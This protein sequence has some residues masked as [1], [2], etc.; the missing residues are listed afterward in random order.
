MTRVTQHYNLGA[1][2][3]GVDFVDVTVDG[4]VPVYIDPT[5]LRHQSGDWAERCVE[6]LQSFFAVLLAAIASDDRPALA[7]LIYPLSEPNETHLG[8]SEGSS[9][10]RSLGSAARAELLI[11]SLRESKAVQSGF[12]SDLEDSALMI[13][14]IDKDIISDIT[15]CVIRRQLIAYTQQQCDFLGI[16]ME[17]QDSGPAWDSTLKQWV[18][19]QVLLPRAGGDKLMLVPKAI[20]RAK[21]T[22]DKGHYYRG[23]LRPYYEDELL[24]NPRQG[25]V[26]TLKSGRKEVVLGKL[27]EEL[28]TTKSDITRQTQEHPDALSR[29]K[30]NLASENSGPLSNEELADRIGAEVEDLR[31]I[32]AE[33]KAVLPGQSGANPYHRAVAKLF[34]ALF[35]LSLGNERIE[36][37]LHKGMKRIDI[38]Y[39]NVSLRGFFHWLGLHHH[40]ATVVVECKNYGH[41]L[42]NPEF[43]QIAMRFSKSRG[44]FGMLA[45]RSFENKETALARA[46][47]IADDG[48]GYVV[49]LDDDDLERLVD[50]Y[51]AAGGSASKRTKHPLLRTR[52]AE[53]VGG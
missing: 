30:N 6:D 7:A 18:S 26:R 29:Y 16:P 35:G 24:A 37:P 11:D 33:I 34:S 22:V 25:L 21:L 5:A 8:S 3:G 1:T 43:D 17:K 41:D 53:L 42:G 4:D 10:G 51:E 20:V 50:D 13:P 47:A 48:H 45:C 9:K 46:K 40:A 39:D 28:G 12:L 52:F 32:L 19:G 31:E 36:T 23:Y 49:V 15:T 27:D 44:M 2:Q 14:G 38:T